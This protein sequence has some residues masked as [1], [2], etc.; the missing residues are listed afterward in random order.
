MHQGGVVTYACNDVPAAKISLSALLHQASFPT[1]ELWLLR[2][3]TEVSI[4]QALSIK[5]T[6]YVRHALKFLARGIAICTSLQRD[7]S[8]YQM[9][10]ID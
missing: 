9:K 5:Q 1:P 7:F 10:S 6:M 4:H 2:S 3:S 8:I